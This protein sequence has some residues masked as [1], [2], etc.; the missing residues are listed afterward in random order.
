MTNRFP[1]ERLD[2]RTQVRSINEDHMKHRYRYVTSSAALLLLAATMQANADEQPRIINSGPV[3][4][5]QAATP[6]FS[7][8]IRKRPL[9]VKNEGTSSAFVTCSFTT[10]GPRGLSTPTRYELF[11]SNT[12]PDADITCTAVGGVEGGTGTNTPEFDVRTTHLVS[13]GE[14]I[15]FT[16]IPGQFQ[17]DILP[18]VFSISCNLQ[19]GMAV[20]DMYVFFSEDIGD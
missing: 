11:V 19:P 2:S 14:P 20:H 15:A 6:V 9:A 10:I 5:C 7:D 18:A 1:A 4:A 12:G 16:Y 8:K 3:T 13:G 17:N